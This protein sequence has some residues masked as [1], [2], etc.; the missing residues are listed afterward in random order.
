MYLLSVSIINT[1]VKSLIPLDRKS[2]DISTHIFVISGTPVTFKV[3]STVSSTSTTFCDTNS[4]RRDTEIFRGPATSCH[5]VI[6]YRDNP[7]RPSI[8]LRTCLG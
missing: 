2:D 3:E 4:L 6:I 8:E 7:V 5:P 1:S